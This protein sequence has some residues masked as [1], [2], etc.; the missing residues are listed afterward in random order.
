MDH[1]ANEVSQ[2]LKVLRQGGIIVYPTDTIW[3]IGCDIL[4]GSAI[5]KIFQIKQRV[6]QKHMIILAA[7]IAM[8]ERYV[9]DAP[10]IAFDLMELSDQPL[11][12]I[13]PKSKNL[14]AELLPNDGSIAIRIPDDPYCKKL[15]KS[16]GRPIVSTSANISGEPAP[17]GYGDIDDRILIQ[18]D[19]AVD[20]RRDEFSTDKSSSI[21]AIGAGGQVRVIRE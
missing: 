12:I 19:Y 4:N 13:F 3:G 16:F 20:W 7:D 11:T 2:S 18:A 17:K 9:D 15:L 21:I 8:T 1:L 6:D 14:P 10:E 5:N